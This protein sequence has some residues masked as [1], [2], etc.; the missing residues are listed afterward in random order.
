[1]NNQKQLQD[2]AKDCVILYAKFDSIDKQYLLNVED[3]PDFD[4]HKFAALLISSDS[5][6]ANEATGADNPRYETHML[7]ALVKFLLN[8]TDRDY[9]CMFTDAWLDGVA[10]Y[11]KEFIQ[12]LIDGALYEY[13]EEQNLLKSHSDNEH[14]VADNKSRYQRESNIW[15]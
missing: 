8:S 1:M 4:L 14:L 7:P 15:N 10:E 2:F 5:A 13:N 6:L 3:I 12:E 11:H 9:E